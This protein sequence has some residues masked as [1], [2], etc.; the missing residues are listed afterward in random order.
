MNPNAHRHQVRLGGTVL[1]A[2]ALVASAC[3]AA[4]GTPGPGAATGAPPSS[5]PATSPEPSSPAVGERRPD[6]EAADPTV[7][8][9]IPLEP[10]LKLAWESKVDSRQPPW[11]FEPVVDP[12]GNIWAPLSYEDTFAITAK[13]G[14]SK[15]TWGTSGTDDGQFTFVSAGN[16][17]G[18]IAF[19]KDGGFVVADSG[20][21][22]IQQFDAN[23]KHVRTWGQ[24]GSDRGRS[25]ILWTSKS[26][27]KITCT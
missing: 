14:T 2:V 21:N 24:F 17:W 13:D 4:S 12:G 23:R 8:A 6:A 1:A 19:R 27:P 22:R 3:S 11:I 15:G 18:A 25:P 10:P 20:N 5:G 16:G 26:M 9:A 7:V